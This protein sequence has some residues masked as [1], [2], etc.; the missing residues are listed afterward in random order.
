MNI[1]DLKTLPEYYNAVESGDKLF[2]V[3]KNDRH[4]QTGDVLVLREYDPTTEE[5]Y[6]GRFIVCRVT[7]VLSERI[8]VKDGYV[9]MGVRVMGEYTNE[10]G[11]NGQ[12]EK[13]GATEV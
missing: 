1:H 12:D 5:A 7:Y 6:S 8:F 4:Y 9:I 2:E 13:D 10:G 3:R 11:L